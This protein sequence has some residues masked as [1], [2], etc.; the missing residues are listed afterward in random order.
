MGKDNPKEKAPFWVDPVGSGKPYEWTK[1]DKFSIGG[2]I[3]RRLVTVVFLFFVAI[4]SIKSKGSFI[5]WIL[6]GFYLLMIGINIYPIWR[7]RSRSRNAKEIQERARNQTNASHIGSAIHVAGHPKLD[8]DQPVVLALD[9]SRLSFYGYDSPVPLD[10]LELADIGSMDL[11]G[12]D[13][14]RVPIRGALDGSAQVL[15]IM[16]ARG[17]DQWKSMFR[18]M[19]PLRP[20]DW[21]HAIQQAKFNSHQ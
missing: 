6:A 12:Y 19:R 10:T 15:E 5:L 7:S 21:Y 9:Q 18:K 20:I 8:R 11:I 16:F 4:S 1:K 17:P 3:F 14:E 13:D 2:F